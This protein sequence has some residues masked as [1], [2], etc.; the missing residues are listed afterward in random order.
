MHIE[1]GMRLLHCSQSCDGL[2]QQAGH[3]SGAKHPRRGRGLRLRKKA[4]AR[5]RLEERSRR[6]DE[7]S[8]VGMT[9]KHSKT[10]RFINPADK[11]STTD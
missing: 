3:L 9:H 11:N 7:R 1:N 2:S 4:E 6:L 10:C 8:H 5:I